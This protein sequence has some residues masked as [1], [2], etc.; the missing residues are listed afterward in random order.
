VLGFAGGALGTAFAL[1]MDR[2]RVESRLAQIEDIAS[3]HEARIRS[4]EDS[5]RKTQNDV[6]WIRAHVE[7]LDP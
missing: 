2:E 5:V 6:A 4:I 7:R 3:D 1:G